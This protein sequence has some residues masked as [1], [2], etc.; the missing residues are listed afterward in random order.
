MNVLM[1][2]LYNGVSVKDCTLYVYGLP[3][4]PSCTKCVIQSGIKR[5][6]IPATKTDK[7]N[8]QQVWEEQSAP[9]FEESGVQITYLEL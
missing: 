4:C 6:V 5:V 7:G 2:A 9:M 1:N 3:V 8:W